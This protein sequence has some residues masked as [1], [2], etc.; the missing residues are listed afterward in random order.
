MIS[1]ENVM[2]SAV[3]PQ[4][5]LL[6][7]FE[8]VSKRTLA[9]E[10]IAKDIEDHCDISHSTFKTYLRSFADAGVLKYR[11]RTSS[12]FLSPKVFISMQRNELEQELLVKSFENFVGD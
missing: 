5:K 11:L 1:L 9:F 2:P 12:I 10:Y 4:F 8:S 6:K 7:L 3:S